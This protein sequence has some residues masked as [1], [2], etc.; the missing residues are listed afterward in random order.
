[1]HTATAREAKRCDVVFT[2]AEFTAADI[3]STLGISR[4]RIR[5]TV[6]LSSFRAAR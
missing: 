4:E 5:S 1:M 3:V 6:T 2:N